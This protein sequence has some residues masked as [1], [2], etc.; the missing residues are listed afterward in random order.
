[1][2][3]HMIYGLEM[4][5]GWR[6]CAC[7]MIVAGYHPCESCMIGFVQ[8]LLIENFQLLFLFRFLPG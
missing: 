4:T 6:A 7:G 5:D 1:M 8:K 2:D 3:G